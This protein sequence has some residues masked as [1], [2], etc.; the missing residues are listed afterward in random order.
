M[1]TSDPQALLKKL[2]KNAPVWA[3]G[4]VSV[5]VSISVCFTAIYLV[6]RSEFQQ[7]LA[8]NYTKAEHEAALDTSTVSEVLGLVKSNSEAINQLSRDNGA[9]TEKVAALE[10]GLNT[11]KLDLKVCQDALKLC[12]K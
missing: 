11:T 12:K 4:V 8:H 10:R 7:W 3:V 9:L 5:V 6:G 2:P 1:D